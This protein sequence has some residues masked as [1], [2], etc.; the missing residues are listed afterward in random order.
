VFV[1]EIENGHSVSTELAEGRQAYM[2]CIEGSASLNDG[3]VTLGMRDA[4]EIVGPVHLN[5]AP[6]AERTHV[7][8]IEMARA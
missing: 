8:L 6:S 2:V 3:A 4:V 7:I 5:I 1:S